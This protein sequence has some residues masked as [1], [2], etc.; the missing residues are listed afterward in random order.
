M[1]YNLQN[2]L[3]KKL[4]GVKM[5]KKIVLLSLIIF[6]TTGILFPTLA[7][8]DIK[9]YANGSPTNISAVS[10]NGIYY[11]PAQSLA[12]PLG[13]SIKWDGTTQTLYVNG[14]KLDCKPEVI[15]GIVHI[16]IESLA[17]SIGANLEW[18]G[19]NNIV[20]IISTGANVTVTQQPTPAPVTPSPVTPLPVTP[21]PVTPQPVTPPP[22]VVPTPVVVI[23]PT[24][25]PTVA[26][27]GGVFIPRSVSNDSFTV[28]VTNLQYQNIIK[29]YYT[30]KSGYRFC[31]INVSQQNISPNVQIYTGTFTLFDTDG[32][33]YDYL[34]GLSNFWLQVLQ[35]GGTNFGHLVYEI[36]S[37]SVPEKLVLYSV[38][39]P[40]LS[41]DLF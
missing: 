2:I 27:S 24:P 23:K 10:H 36:P 20:N 32:H 19:K 40:T 18:D 12:M 22:T 13:L 8:T 16:P 33:S 3:N 28:T 26:T 9:V 15:S 5:F 34:E 31:I 21:P 39:N 17:Y 30:P 29:N 35:P 1:V 4:R 6:L 25:V 14:Q 38:N 7:Q 11:V 41:I 37:N